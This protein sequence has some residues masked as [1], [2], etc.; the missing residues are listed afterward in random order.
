[1]TMSTRD[2]TDLIYVA[3]FAAVTVLFLAV[4]LGTARA[5][6]PGPSTPAQTEPYECGVEQSARP[7]ARFHIRY[8]YFGLLFVLFDVETVLLFAVATQF[9]A[10][11]AMWPI[12]T[13]EVL[14]FVA[15][16]L[17]ALGYAWR[18]GALAW[19]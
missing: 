14:L 17:G 19:Q 6:R 5:L 1:M 2:I 7:W 10:L 12:V 13:G 18:K 11:R 3:V 4:V 16:V 15:L 8:Y 9:R